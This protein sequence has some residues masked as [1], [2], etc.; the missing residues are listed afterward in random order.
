[1]KKNFAYRWLRH[2]V[3]TLYG[4]Y[5]WKLPGTTYAVTT[6]AGTSYYSWLP[7]FDTW[8]C[9]ASTN[10]PAVKVGRVVRFVSPR[11][12]HYPRHFGCGVVVRFMGT[13][14]LIYMRPAYL[15]PVKVT[16]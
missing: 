10:T 13:A 14:R 7:R 4:S 15:S 5:L 3:R 12:D 9:S 1:M 8:T 11:S 6:A 2:P 16:P